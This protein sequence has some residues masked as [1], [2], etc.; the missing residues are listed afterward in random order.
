MSFHLPVHPYVRR[1]I[2]LHHCTPDLKIFCLYSE[3]TRVLTSLRRCTFDLDIC[4]S[5]MLAIL[6][7]EIS[8]QKK[9]EKNAMVFLAISLISK[10]S[11]HALARLPLLACQSGCSHTSCREPIKSFIYV[12]SIILTSVQQFNWLSIY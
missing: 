11:Y 7:Q 9:E 12:R 1:L 4:F 10:I 6:H 2:S 8:C 3:K 5:P